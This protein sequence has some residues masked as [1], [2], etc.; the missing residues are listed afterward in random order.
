MTSPTFAGAVGRRLRF[1]SFLLA[2]SAAFART[3]DEDV[4]AEIHIWL[5]RITRFVH[6]DRINIWECT[7]DGSRMQRSFVH[8]RSGEAP[9]P[10]RT[11]ETL[12]WLI[13]QYRRGRTVVWRRVPE[14]I[15]AEAVAERAAALR[16]GT[17]SM[18]GI[19]LRFDAGL[20]II[21]FASFRRDLPWPPATIRRLRLVGEIISCS[22][23]RKR[24][25]L[26]LHAS[27]L[28][29]RALL[30][31]LPDAMF[32]CSRDGIYLDYA[33]R[34][35][36][37]DAL[38][39]GILGR[40]IEDVLPAGVAATLRAGL[41]RAA[42]THE[43]V[44]LD[45]LAPG[46]SGPRHHEIRIACREDGA[47]VCIE[48]DITERRRD[49][50]RLRESEERFRAAFDHSAIGIALVSLNGRWLQ[51]NAALCRI[52]GY[53][54]QTL[55]ALDFQTITHPDDR[56]PNLVFLR[57]ALAG[58]IDH[59]EFEKRYIHKDGHTISAL[60]TTALVR[61]AGGAPLYFVS[62][63]QDMT[64]RLQ[65]QTQIER[66]RAELAHVGRVN[67]MGH[68]TASLAHQL[69]QPITAIL[70]NAEAGQHIM[71][72]AAPDVADLCAILAD[73]AE[74]ARGA[75]EVIH[76]VTGMLRKER[77]PFEPLDL[78]QLVSHVVDVTRSD[79]IL[80]NVQLVAHLT[81]T[82][83][84]VVGDAIQLQ[85]VVLNLL[86]NGAEAMSG[87]A[88]PE[89]L[90]AVST[91]EREHEVE[92]TVCDRGTGVEPAHL[93]RIFNPF[94]T[95]KADGLGMGL[96]ICSE[97]VRAHGGR[98]WAENNEGP[99]LTVRCCIPLAAGSSAFRPVAGARLDIGES[100]R[101]RTAG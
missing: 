71:S 69:L 60:L 96:H 41:Q 22:I 59:Y 61:D 83:S 5:R 70:G 91:L 62:Q 95:T 53:D 52:L 73:I 11:V 72:S 84:A 85:Q 14:D 58:E 24:A 98:L 63:I 10:C 45:Y 25:A 32:I 12:P 79:F 43:C 101:A 77:R 99:G 18:L 49:E 87:S 9:P 23:L 80:R 46:R 50:A 27:E 17:R 93:H 28:R 16:A 90:L 38:R 82:R 36:V 75:A 67:L 6:V 15:P 2:L 29:N 78:N 65:A 37:H 19:P 40:R 86:L 54:E 34:D 21:E 30:Q 26:H 56:E 81:A 35:S 57:R 20:C 1:E 47:L 74:S 51:V 7:P 64:E 97:I 39:P 8:C 31:A 94:F 76:G 66:L 55:L 3:S 42:Q 13:E 89:R 92:L 68:L 88:L 48:R 4:D 100:S 44:E 33:F